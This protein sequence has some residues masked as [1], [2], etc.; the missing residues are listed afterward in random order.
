MLLEGQQVGHYQ[1]VQ[2]RRSG[3][4]G[5]VYLAEDMR[6]HRQVAIKVI[7]TDSMRF[8]DDHRAKETARLF[9]R[10]AQ[11]IAQLDHLHILPLYDSG[12]ERV[13]GMAIMYM[14]MPFRYEGSFTEWL[15]V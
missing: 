9:L 15:R 7:R 11:L 5:E 14:V 2:L 10:E 3:G 1:L 8:T 12:E 6:L 13:D 4:M